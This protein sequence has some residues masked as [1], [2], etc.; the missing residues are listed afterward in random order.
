M[1]IVKTTGVGPWSLGETIVK[2]YVDLPR[3]E[4]YVLWIGEIWF[5]TTKRIWL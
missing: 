4:C 2:S 5:R 3:I 1:L